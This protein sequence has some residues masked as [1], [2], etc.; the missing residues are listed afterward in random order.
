VRPA[1]VKKVQT[2]IEQLGFVRSDLARQLKAG[3]SNT[4]GLV[5]FDAGNPFFNEIARGAEDAAAAR[6]YST[7]LGNSDSTPEREKQYLQ[8]F[9]QQRLAGVLI[10]PIREIYEQVK[11][12]RNHGTQSVLVDRKEDPERCCSV[13]V[14]DFAGGRMAVQHLLA[15]GK[16]RLVFVAGSITFQQ[17]ADRLAGAMSAVSD[18]GAEAQLSVME[19][20]GMTVIAGRNVGLEIAKLAKD[21]RPDGIFAAND[22]LALGLVQAFM[23]NNQISIP[24]E[25]ALIG[26]D[27]IDF[28]QAAIVPLSSIRQ[29]A[30]LIGSTAVDLVIDEI[31]NPETHKHQQVTFQPEL[32]I[33]ASTEG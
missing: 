11:E 4:L 20:A 19:S 13:S 9:D 33:R 31:Q 5:V 17:V 29:P 27:D 2:A 18:F 25:I 10:S 1:T 16:R 7:L 14:D 26:Y 22:L 12:L 3:K 24:S 28:A 30:R 8:L 23:F 21:K 32:V 15:I 6:S